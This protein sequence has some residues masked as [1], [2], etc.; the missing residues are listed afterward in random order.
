MKQNITVEQ[1]NE[2]SK[3]GL[4]RLLTWR[5]KKTKEDLE[6]QTYVIVDDFPDQRGLS[7]FMDIGQMIE[8]LD[9]KAEINNLHYGR[10]DPYWL[11]EVTERSI[12]KKP[13][14][15]HRDYGGS[16]LCDVLWEAVKEVLNEQH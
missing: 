8:F 13:A 1:L 3:R 2:L 7:R 6:G 16:E 11:L 14:S 9:T 10:T 5:E 15:G 12:V 4:K